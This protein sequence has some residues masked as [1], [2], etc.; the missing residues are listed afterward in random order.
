MNRNEPSTMNSAKDVGCQRGAERR[1]REQPHVDQRIGEPAL[2]AEENDADDE[3]DDNRQH[4]ATSGQ[5]ILGHA[6]DADR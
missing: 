4:A 1:R 2:A 5:P 3:T 6:L